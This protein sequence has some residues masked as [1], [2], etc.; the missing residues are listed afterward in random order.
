MQSGDRASLPAGAESAPRNYS[1]HFN[2]AENSTL[3]NGWHLIWI[4]PL[5]PV[6]YDVHDRCFKKP[7]QVLLMD[8]VAYCP[9][10]Q[11]KLQTEHMTT[12]TRGSLDGTDAGG[13]KYTFT[14]FQSAYAKVTGPGYYYVKA[15]L[16]ENAQAIADR[17]VPHVE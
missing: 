9:H 2:F 10:C 1:D 6:Q 15:R 7:I 14:A 16:D 11:M 5:D 4:E 8:A 17:V 13:S 12:A 3:L